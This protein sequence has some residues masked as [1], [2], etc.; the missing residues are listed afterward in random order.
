ML[1]TEGP[2]RRAVGEP[3]CQRK[4]SE[5]PFGVHQ[6]GA[7]LRTTRL[8]A[9]ATLYPNS[10][11][12]SVCHSLS[13]QPD[14]QRLPL[15]I[16]TARLP[17]FA[18]LYPNSQTASICHSLSQQPDCQRLPLFIPTARLP[19]FATLYPN[20]QT[21][22]VCHSLSQQPD[23]QS[24]PLFIPT[25]RLL[26]FAT[27]YPNSHAASRHRAPPLAWVLLSRLSPLDPYCIS[28]MVLGHLEIVVSSQQWSI[29]CMEL[30]PLYTWSC[31]PYTHGVVTLIHMELLPSDT[32]TDGV[33]T[34]IHMKLLPSDTCSC[35]PQTHAVVTLI[36]MELLPL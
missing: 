28:L 19:V 21:A 6:P 33:V 3:S 18:T 9:F 26:A 5:C 22:S 10:Q 16:P 30:L 15:F 36:H 25:A 14:C 32:W 31:Y 8:P 17:A 13:Q 35:Y 34:L 24:L 12:A 2:S 23:C 27:L 7:A 4:G 20:S 11:T 29:L 1:S